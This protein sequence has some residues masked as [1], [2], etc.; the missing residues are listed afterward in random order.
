MPLLKLLC[1]TYCHQQLLSSSQYSESHNKNK[2]SIEDIEK[3]CVWRAL[4]KALHFS[5]SDREAGLQIIHT[6]LGICIEEETQREMERGYRKT[7][8]RAIE[9]EL[10]ERHLQMKPEIIEKVII[11]VIMIIILIF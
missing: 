7:L 1:T 9:K 6:K 11:I 2:N 3:G 8:I 10:E 5:E 4:I